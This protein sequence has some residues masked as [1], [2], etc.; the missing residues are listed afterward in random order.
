MSIVREASGPGPRFG[1]RKQP[2]LSVLERLMKSQQRRWLEDDSNPPEAALTE[3]ERLE[4]KQEA[5]KDGEIRGPATRPVDH[6][7]LLLQE[8]ALSDDGPGAARTEEPG[9]KGQEVSEQYEQ[10]FV[11]GRRRA[12]WASEQPTR[13]G[14]LRGEFAT[15]RSTMLG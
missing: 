2:I 14:C 3:E 5:I 12:E 8:E 6:Q 13:I 11:G 7:E 1:T 10:T 4:A 15:H 9:D